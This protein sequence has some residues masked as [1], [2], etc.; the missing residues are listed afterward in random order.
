MVNK[1]L[2]NMPQKHRLVPVSYCIGDHKLLPDISR[3][4]VKQ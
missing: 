1:W 4:N 3:A 2:N